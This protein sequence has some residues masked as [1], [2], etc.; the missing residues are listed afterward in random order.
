MFKIQLSTDLIP[1]KIVLVLVPFAVFLFWATV[2]IVVAVVVFLLLLIFV[3]YSLYTIYMAPVNLAYD[4]S[5]LFITSRK[6][7]K[8]IQLKSIQHI[9]IVSGNLALRKRW[10]IT[11]MENSEE[12]TI[13][14][15][16]KDGQDTM[17]S[18]AKT[19]RTKN[20]AANWIDI[21]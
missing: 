21:Y 4:G 15:Y 14:F 2:P 1:E 18:F 3:P 5:L 17:A 7:E 9:A 13:L 10:Q 19:V 20:P 16:A 8:I 12:E 6:T 11:Y